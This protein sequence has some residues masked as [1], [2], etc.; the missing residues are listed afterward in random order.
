MASPIRNSE[1]GDWRHRMRDPEE[2]ASISHREEVYIKGASQTSQI[3]DEGNK[4]IFYNPSS[5]L[6]ASPKRNSEKG[7]RFV[8]TKYRQESDTDKVP[9]TLK[10][11]GTNLY[12]FCSNGELIL[13]GLENDETLDTIQGSTKR[14][15][16]FRTKRVKGV[17]FESVMYLEMFICTDNINAPS[18]VNMSKFEDPKKI[19]RF[20]IDG[21]SSFVGEI[22]L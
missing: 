12:L 13:E 19:F 10:I 2:G 22:L 3:H 6:M 4:L 14:F 21:E 20:T 1:E 18:P 16:F 11:D 15:L 7:A 5:G 9:V 8:I 17:M